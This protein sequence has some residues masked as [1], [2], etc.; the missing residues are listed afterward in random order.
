LAAPIDVKP[1]RSAARLVLIATTLH[2][3]LVVLRLGVGWKLIATEA[4]FRIFCASIDEALAVAKVRANVPRHIVGDLA[5][6]TKGTLAVD[7]VDITARLCPA[8]E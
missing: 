3:T 6:A 2:G 1:I 5:G 8:W 7:I 4:F